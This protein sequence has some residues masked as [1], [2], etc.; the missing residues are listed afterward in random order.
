M[1][2]ITNI[3]TVSFNGIEFTPLKGVY[4]RTDYVEVARRI[5]EGQYEVLGICRKLI[6]TDLFF[7]VYFVMGLKKA[8]HPF[9]V[10]MCQFVENGDRGDTLDVWA[11]FHYK[12]TIITIAETLQFHLDPKNKGKCTGILAYARPLAKKFLESI[13]KMCESS[14]FLKA[15]FPDVLYEKPESE[16][17]KWSLDEG[18]VFKNAEPSRKESTVEAWGLVEGMP[19]GRHY[20]RMIFDDIETADIAESPE[21]LDKVFSKFEMS[22][23]NLGTGSDEDIT[24]I[25]GTYYS[26]FGPI[27]RI[28]EMVYPGTQDKIFNLRVVPGSDNGQ[29]DG[30]PVLMDEK[31]WLKI[32]ASRHFNS[33]Q[34][35]DP[36]PQGD[37]RLDSSL[38]IEEDDFPSLHKFMLI[39]PAGDDDTNVGSGD[40]WGVLVCGVDGSTDDLGANDIYILD[41]FIGPCGETEI[42]RVLTEMYLRNGLIM[43]VGYERNLNT[44]PGWLI[45]FTN[46]LKERQITLSEDRKNLM[47]LKHGGRNKV[48]RIT[49]ALQLPLLNGKIK[50]S[51][52]IAKVYRDLLKEEMDKFPYWQDGGIDALAYLY[53]VIEDPY[54]KLMLDT[55][56]LGRK[57][58]NLLL[59]P[60]KQYHAQGWM[61]G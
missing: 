49:S 35:C 1:P 52:L 20:E 29:V 10:K 58:N 57:V 54:L 28:Q 59:F 7:I 5:K 15:C 51:K 6:L 9:V 25:I 31:Q 61:A 22:Y 30:K 2:E 8:N 47:R 13:K 39:D 50:I 44:T 36:T 40:H 43:C 45:H 4:Y 37:R 34:L 21:M 3:K 56:P 53:D 14:D 26:H 16:S 42:V 46:A 33:Q 19:T 18:L 24:R 27:T 12:S 38:L 41:A 60:Q 23:G 55:V 32:K 11:R 17:P 48:T